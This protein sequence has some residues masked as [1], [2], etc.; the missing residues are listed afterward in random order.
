MNVKGMGK[1][2]KGLRKQRGL[3]QGAL[4]KAAGISQIYVAK[5]EAGDKIPSIPTLVKLAK[6]LKVTVG[7]LLE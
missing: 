5:I 2:L 1:M 6:V 3:T 7:E 4:A